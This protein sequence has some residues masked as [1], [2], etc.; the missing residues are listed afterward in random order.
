[1]WG[2]HLRYVAAISEDGVVGH[3]PLLG[4]YNAAHLIVFLTELEQACQGDG[5]TYVFVWDNVRFHH[6]EVVQVWFHSYPRFV[7][8]YLPSYTPFLNSIEE[9]FSSWWWNAYNRNPRERATLLLAMD[10]ACDDINADQCQV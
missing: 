10:E 1:M 6:A 7:I 8:L 5:V 9:S 2:K 4:S 3:R